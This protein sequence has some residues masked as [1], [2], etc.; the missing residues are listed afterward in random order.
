MRVPA[1]MAAVLALA[2]CD[3]GNVPPPG[4]EPL[5]PSTPQVEPN[6]VVLK[7]DGLVAGP[8]AFYFAAGRNE[9]EAAIARAIGKASVTGENAEC[10]AGP[11]AY[12]TFSG[13]L[14]VHFQN[15]NLVGWNW[16]KEAD[17]IRLSGDLRVGMPRAGIEAK[18]GFSMIEDSTLGEEFA[19]GGAV[20]GFIEGDEVSMLYAGTQCFF[21]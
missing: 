14:T 1:V 7:G 21:R 5:R 13:G 2:A 11:I 8:E 18:S 10:G 6:E 16:R 15:G 20:G 9:V 17:F 4:Q 12:S 3:S 19:L